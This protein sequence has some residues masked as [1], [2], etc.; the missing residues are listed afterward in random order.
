[1]KG[2]IQLILTAVIAISCQTLPEIKPDVAKTKTPACPSPFLKESHRFVH[3]IETRRGDAIRGGIIGVTVADPATRF[4][5]CALMTAEGMVLLEAEANPSLHVL[6]ALPPFNY[7]AF[8]ENMIED[9]RLIFFAPRGKFMQLGVLDDGSKI[10]RWREEGGAFVDIIE[11]QSDGFEINKYTRRGS[12]KRRVR[13]I[14]SAE[15]VYS[16]IELSASELVSYSLK[17]TLVEAEPIED[18]PKTNKDAKAEE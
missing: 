2:L 7:P 11:R 6:R 9:I 16:Q 12:L 1:M 18:E 5:S 4:I 3:A 8:A 15:N 10:C 14:L 17:M 13:L